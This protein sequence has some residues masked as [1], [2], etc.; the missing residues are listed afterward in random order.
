M[1]NFPSPTPGER[2]MLDALAELVLSEDPL[3]D[4]DA[5]AVSTYTI[6]LFLLHVLNAA[7]GGGI[8]PFS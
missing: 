7:D 1:M 4:D 8:C 2:R 3:A 6:A 5:Y